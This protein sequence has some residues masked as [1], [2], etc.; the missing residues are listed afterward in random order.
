[1][2]LD[3]L[4]IPYEL[5]ETKYRGHATLLAEEA[6]EKYPVIVAA[7]GDGTINE[8][9][10]GLLKKGRNKTT[11]G[12]I[13]VGLGNDFAKNLNIK[14][15]DDSILALS[16]YYLTRENSFL[17]DAGSVDWNENGLPVR[18][19]F[20]S[21]AGICFDAE[22]VL[23][24]LE[25]ELKN[26]KFDYTSLAFQRLLKIPSQKSMIEITSDYGKRV[27][28]TRITS[29]NIALGKTTGRIIKIAP[30]ASNRD[31]FFDIALM[32]DASSIGRLIFFPIIILGLHPY[33]PFLSP[34]VEYFDS[35]QKITGVN[36]LA[37]G[38]PFQAEGEYFGK[39][40]ANF[41]IIPGAIDAI[42]KRK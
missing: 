3:S 35:R 22:I 28:E 31:G 5:S 36:I 16:D 11:F 10:N 25:K 1:K 41:S 23:I 13:P 6:S 8:V 18:R 2:K 17:V 42:Y 15:I 21:V 19:Y 26:E 4:G 12:V 7:G 29:M 20:C 24:A 9:V 40:P 34:W 37:E 39:S 30:R 14:T 32:K 38:I 33:L 27:F